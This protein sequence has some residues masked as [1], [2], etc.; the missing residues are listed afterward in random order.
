MRRQAGS[1]VPNV[2]RSSPPMPGFLQIYL[3]AEFETRVSARR[4]GLIFCCLHR[5]YECAAGAFI[6]AEIEMFHE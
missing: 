1:A 6:C 4:H 2:E 5:C 3:Y